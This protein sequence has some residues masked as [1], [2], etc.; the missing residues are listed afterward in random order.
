MGFTTTV[1]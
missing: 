1:V